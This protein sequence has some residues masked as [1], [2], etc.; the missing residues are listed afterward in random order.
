MVLPHLQYCLMVWGNFEA[1]RNKVQ[2]SSEASGEVC[3]YYCRKAWLL[4]CRSPVFQVWD[5]QGG[6]PISAAA[7]DAC[8]EFPQRLAS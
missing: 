2:D 5:P 6:V 4:S 1:D 7:E 8:L 3:G